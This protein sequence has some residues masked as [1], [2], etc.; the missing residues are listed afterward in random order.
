MS[1]ITITPVTDTPST[2][3]I[4]DGTF[5]T[6][7]ALLFAPDF[8]QRLQLATAL[9]LQVIDGEDV[10]VTNHANRVV[11]ARNASL[12][13]RGT[14]ANIQAIVLADGTITGSSTDQDVFD[15]IQALL[16]K[17]IYSA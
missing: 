4:T 9:T 6:Q 12:D 16:V 3:V 14:A 10:G 17:L 5:A 11:W 1:A 2:V 7:A 15:A 13:I 8:T